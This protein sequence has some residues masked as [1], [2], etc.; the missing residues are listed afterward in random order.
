VEDFKNYYM[1]IALEEARKAF[2]KEEVPIGAVIVKNNQII[3]RGHNKKETEKSPL[4]HAELVAIEDASR[5]I[6]DWR[7]TDCEIYV[8]IEPCLMCAG[9]IIEARIKRLIFGAHEK[10]TGAF[11]GSLNLLQL[12]PELKLEVISG[13]K[14]EESLGLLQEFFEILRR[15]G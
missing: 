7:L 10:K 11:G 4:R 15:D 1:S 8:S 2:L 9:A 14:A 12:K 5:K 3:G 13:V 6:G